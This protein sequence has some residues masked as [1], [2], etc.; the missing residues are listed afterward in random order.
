VENGRLEAHVHNM[1]SPEVDGPI[2]FL[3]LAVTAAFMAAVVLGYFVH[4]GLGFSRQ[5]IRDLALAVGAI[6]GLILAI[7]YFGKMLRKPK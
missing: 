7:E 5:E 4:Y 6:I 2:T 1:A 3:V